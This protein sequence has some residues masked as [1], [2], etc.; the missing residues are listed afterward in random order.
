[1]KTAEWLCTSCGATNRV[2]V[3]DDEKSTQD[4]CVQC[5]KRHVVEEDERP[6]RWRS[7]AK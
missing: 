5:R 4:K 7:K 3:A 6:V 1:M 2:L